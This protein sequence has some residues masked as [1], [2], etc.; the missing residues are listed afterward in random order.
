MK[1]KL[2]RKTFIFITIFAICFSCYIVK[3]SDNIIIESGIYFQLGKYN[4][5][6][7]LWR[8]VVS[9]D[10]NGILMVSDKIL[11]YKIFDASIN[12]LLYTSRC[13]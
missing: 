3:A 13:V 9:D 6:P 7:I 12:C 4:N 10:Q 2:F 11:C 1:N 5:K 8:S